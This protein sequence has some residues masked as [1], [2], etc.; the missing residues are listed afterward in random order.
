[1]IFID[2]SAWIAIEDKGDTNHKKA[3]EFK[4]KILIS[5]N[6]L[7]T[8]N[9]V[10]DETYTLMLMNSGYAKT[11][12]F[13]YNLDQ[14]IRNNLLIIYYIN[15]EIEKYSWEVFEQF[16]RDKMWSFTDCTSKVIMEKL[17]LVEVFAFDRHFEQMGFFRKP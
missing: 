2:T 8:T 6:R 9:Y 11:V 12:A 14:F 7:I 13:K 16:N 10:L 1:M 5:R 17:G 4:N 3:M 15:T